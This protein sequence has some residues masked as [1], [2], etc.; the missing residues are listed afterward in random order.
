MCCAFST[1]WD[2]LR[3]DV[4]GFRAFSEWFF[5]TYSTYFISPLRLSGSAVK[6]LFSQY[7]HN[8]GGKLDSVNYCT[9]RA[10]RLVKQTVSTHHSGK[11]YRDQHLNKT[12]LP[13]Q[14]KKYN[15]NSNTKKCN[16]N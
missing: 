16:C 12:E 11:G 10:A 8:A 9:A 13:L 14:K 7:K 15:K 4:Y 6:S 2:L 1:A 5:R 3:I